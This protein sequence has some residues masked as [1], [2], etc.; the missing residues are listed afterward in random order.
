MATD[1]FAEITESIAAPIAAWLAEH[2]APGAVQLAPPT[3]EGAGDLAMACHRYARTL[4]K[5]PQ[6]IAADIAELAGAHPLVA[7]ATAVAGFLNLRFDWAAVAAKVV[8]WARTDDG[9]LGRT[10]VLA[11]QTVLVEYSSPNTNKPQH[12]GHC[13]NNILGH[14][15]ATL[16]GAAGAKVVRVNLINDRGI[17]ICKSMVAYRKF[18]DGVTPTSTGIKGDHLVGGFYV[19]FA[20]AFKA[21]YEEQF[22]GADEPPKTD[23]WFNGESALGQETRAMLQAWEAGDPEV[24]AL[25]ATM[26]SWC[27]A[28]FKQT[29]DRMG[30]HFDQIDKESTT[31]LLGKDLIAEGVERGVFH[32][33]DDGATVFDLEKIGLEGQKAVLRADGTSLYVTQD[34]GTAVSRF[35]THGFDQLIYVV[36]NEQNHHFRV[37]FGILEALR[38]EL[39]GRLHHLSYG[40]VELPDGRMK[41]REGNVVDADDLMDELH[42]A[43][44][45]KARGSENLADAADAELAATAESIALGGLKFFLLKYAPATTFVF[46][47]ETSISPNGETGV[48]CQY[49]YARAGRVLSKMGALDAV[50]PDWAVLTEEKP[51]AVL[52]A[53]L[54]FTGEM[55]SA[56]VDRK[57]S[58]ATKATYDIVNAFNTFYGDSDYRVKDAEGGRKVALAQL[59][60]AAHRMIGAGM[61]LL[62]IQPVDAM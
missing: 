59:V 51:R 56:A 12:L 4:R 22:V 9:A 49:S 32:V 24:R 42:A 15:V 13:R 5:A 62:G 17:H 26:N 54:K 52:T 47:K 31:Y 53:M 29:Y 20:Q 37:L 60:E 44:L 10:D 1:L 11:G 14:T 18:G 50:D 25:W 39:K 57:P 19:K 21:E 8:D 2:D 7:E 43:A 40:M 46:D 23:A 55:A 34:L 33:I 45:A 28:G 16:M 58:L 38:P 48:C 35:E 27:E 41:S 3:R 6:A 61:A 30:V 36:G